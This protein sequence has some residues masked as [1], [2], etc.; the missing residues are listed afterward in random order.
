MRSGL[1]AR[2]VAG[3]IGVGGRVLRKLGFVG[4]VV[5]VV[6]VVGRS[7]QRRRELRWRL[8]ERNGERRTGDQS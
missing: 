4:L 1:R 3:R 7:Q 5:V 8:V 2:A 6:V